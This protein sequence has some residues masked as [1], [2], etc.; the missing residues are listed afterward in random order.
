MSKLIPNNPS[1]YKPTWAEVKEGDFLEKAHMG[2]IHV[3]YVYKSACSSPLSLI[4]LTKPKCNWSDISNWP[5]N[6]NDTTLLHI[7]KPGNKFT[8]GE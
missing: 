4:S 6:V 5:K 8:I 7:F 3:C 1:N 2:I